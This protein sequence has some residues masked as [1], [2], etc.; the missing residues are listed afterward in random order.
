MARP[1]TTLG[2]FFEDFTVG[3]ELPH[4]IPRTITV[5][6]VALNTALYGSRH[7]FNCADPFAQSLGLA[8]A[9]V[10]DLLVFHIVAGKSVT[11]ISLNAV[12]NLG[13]AD[14]RFHALT[15]P[16]DTLG[17]S[18]R[19]IGLKQNSDGKTG[20]VYVHTAGLNQH[21]E[22]VVDYLRWVIVH[23]RD[24]DAPAPDTVVPDLPDRVAPESLYLPPSLD[25]DGY[26]TD[27]SGSPHLWDDYEV[28]EKIDH[29]DGITIE[30]A[31]H[32][33][34]TKLYQNTSRVHLDGLAAA[35]NRWGRRLIVGPYIIS[36]ARAL[37]HNGL[38]NAFKVAAIN[39]AKH[40][41]PAFAGNT[42]YAWSEVLEK[43]ELPNHADFG[44]LRL[45]TI[46]TNDQPCGAFPGKTG[47]RSYDASV[48]LDWDY[49][50]L[51]P[52]R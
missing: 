29:I 31:E 21:G 5:G 20:I 50:V 25:A 45:R 17:A 41:A 51:M 37:S 7:V 11:D 16:G 48:L 42:I 47:E 44:A 1:K 27:L 23:K 6:D 19:V 30:E 52:R 13:Y 9:P 35:S 24:H 33:L 32:V 46:A 12:A 26:D 10:D 40:V 43:A 38:A 14:M 2:N 28:G 34:A 36:L 15:Y 18:S 49:W 39:G 22:V 8:R 3:H 4:P